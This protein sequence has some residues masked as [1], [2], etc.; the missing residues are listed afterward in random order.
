[1]QDFR[2]YIAVRSK[3]L[4]LDRSIDVEEII[5]D[6]K[7]FE[8]VYHVVPYN[9]NLH[10]TFFQLVSKYQ[11]KVKQVH[12][13]NIAATMI[14]NKIK[15]IFTTNSVDFKRYILQEINIILQSI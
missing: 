11:G 5:L 4:Y 12:D 13:C 8:K 14:E 2:E 6:V 3:I 7:E 10:N 9:Q 1:M 15:N